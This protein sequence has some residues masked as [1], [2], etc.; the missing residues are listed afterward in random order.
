[1]EEAFQGQG[2]RAQGLFWDEAEVEKKHPRRIGVGVG[3]GGG[4]AHARMH[5]GFYPGIR[6][7]S[8]KRVGRGR[9]RQVENQ[10]QAGKVGARKVWSCC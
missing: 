2:V 7:K 1:V 5:K 3:V 6:P 4:G 10:G 8:K 9:N